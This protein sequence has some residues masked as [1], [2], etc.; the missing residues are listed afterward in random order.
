[1]RKDDDAMDEALRAKTAALQ[2][3]DDET[4]DGR[5]DLAD[6]KH[7]LDRLE[8]Q[9]ALQDR[10]NRTLLRNQ[11]LRMAVGGAVLVLVCVLAVVLFFYTRQAYE[12]VLQASA[13]VNE[14]A[15]TLQNSL[16]A[17]DTAQLDQMMQAMPEIVDQLSKID[18]DALNEVLNELPGVLDSVQKL[19]QDMDQLRSWFTGL[20]SL[21]GG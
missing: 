20:G 4:G 3:N 7:Q 6:L 15:A 13:Q 18:V 8:A 12:Q 2:A 16:N 10:Q 14:L 11:R 19:Q 9:L 5:I 21:F 17:L 1:M